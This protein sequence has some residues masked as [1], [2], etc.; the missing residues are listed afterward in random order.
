[1]VSLFD[2]LEPCGF[3]ILAFPCNQFGNQEPD[4]NAQIAEFAEER[5][6]KFQMMAKVDVNGK[7]T[8]P[9][10]KYLKRSFPGD[11]HWNFDTHFLV[12]RNGTV[13][14]RYDGASTPQIA[15]EVRELV[16]TPGAPHCCS[17]KFSRDFPDLLELEEQGAAQAE[18][19][20]IA[21]AAVDE[22]KEDDPTRS[23][24][25]AAPIA[26]AEKALPTAPSPDPGFYMSP[27]RNFRP[28]Y[29]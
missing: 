4:S 18:K 6:V 10:W 27:S 26:D 12:A 19:E 1:M 24:A 21:N 7:Q 20:R 14:A 2:E 25:E 23:T 28:G 9:V 29:G 11:V 15:P 17:A 13:M 3:Q 22:A 16:C 8:S 5:G